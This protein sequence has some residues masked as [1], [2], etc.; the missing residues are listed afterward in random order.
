MNVNNENNDNDNNYDNNDN[1]NINDNNDNNDNNNNNNNN[2][3]NDNNN[4]TL[5]IWIIFVCLY[6]CLCVCVSMKTLLPKKP[7]DEYTLNSAKT[8]SQYRTTP[9]SY[10]HYS[11]PNKSELSE[12]GAFG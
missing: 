7:L 11:R 6:V 3:N 12:S 4:N 10:F 5:L 2:N 9:F 1:N 8:Y